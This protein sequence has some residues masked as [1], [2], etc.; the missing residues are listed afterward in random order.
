MENFRISLVSDPTADQSHFFA[1]IARMKYIVRWGLMRNTRAENIQE[2]SLQ[3]AMIAHALA[4][5]GNDLFGEQ[6]DV[7]RI[8]IVAMYHDASE[9]ITGD[10]PTPIKYFRQDIL[11]SY[12]AL[13]AHAERKLTGL[14][15]PE[16]QAAFADVLE[17]ER[18]EPE[19]ARVIKA[20]D[21]LSAYLKCIE[22]RRAGNKEFQRAEQY[23]L[24]KLD[25]MTDLPA[26]AY[27]RESFVSGFELTLDDLSHD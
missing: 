17:S 18:V 21:S 4:V 19:V 5:I 22:E 9:I 25:A 1:Y 27:F 2:H 14:L 6:H 13:E 15:P 11:E 8:V 24:A 26:V 12:K 23:L 16:L 20:A 3:V 7:G 10:L